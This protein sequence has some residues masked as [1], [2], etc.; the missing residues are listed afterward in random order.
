MKKDNIK[1]LTV[2]ENFQW[3]EEKQEQFFEDCKGKFITR[4]QSNV[5]DHS[6]RN[7]SNI[8]VILSLYTI[9]YLKI[10]IFNIK[11]MN[12]IKHFRDLIRSND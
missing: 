11:M 7:I 1:T 3:L 5:R 9:Y 2:D 6:I 8:S 4:C 10:K 12:R